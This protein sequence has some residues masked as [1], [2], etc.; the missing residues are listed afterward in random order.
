MP[1][2]LLCETIV[3]CGAYLMA[4]KLDQDANMKGSPVVARMSNV[5]FKRMVTP[6]DE[7]RL[8]AEHLRSMMDAHMMKGRALRDGKV[9]CSLD[10]TVMLVNEDE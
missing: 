4:V 8:E 7:L 6:G 2:V 5:K 3:Q 10:F 9:V 1:G